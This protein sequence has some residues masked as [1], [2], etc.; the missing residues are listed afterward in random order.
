[1]RKAL[2]L[3]IDRDFLANVLLLGT[4]TPEVSYVGSGFPGST[5]EA[6]FRSE[7]GDLFATDVEQAK[8]L[9][10]EAGY[11][12]GAG[13]PVIEC[14]YANNSAD[15]TTIFEYLPVSYTHLDVY[16]RQT[17]CWKASS[18]VTTRRRPA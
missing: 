11:P 7:G 14:S 6:D 10:A 16:K 5:D 2:S 13:F 18:F 3:V 15:Y 12:D 17:A 8:A 1:M 9:L 4:K